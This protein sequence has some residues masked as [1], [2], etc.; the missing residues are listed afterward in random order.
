MALLQPS[1]SSCFRSAP[2]QNWTG[3]S[4][5]CTVVHRERMPAALLCISPC[6]YV[7]DMTIDACQLQIL[8]RR[9][10]KDH[11]QKHS[12]GSASTVATSGVVFFV[13]GQWSFPVENQHYYFSITLTFEASL[14][15]FGHQVGRNSMQD[16]LMLKNWRTSNSKSR[17]T[18]RSPNW[19]WTVDK[20]SS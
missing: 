16:Y 7:V 5:T 8:C 12:S 18:T 13:E 4:Y 9:P 3:D 11:H 2:K 1:I 10:D 15:W 14:I 17:A 19:P 6:V 20:L